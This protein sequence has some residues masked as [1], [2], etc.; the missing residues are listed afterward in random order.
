MTEF[1]LT[2]H[3]A[4]ILAPGAS[5]QLG[6]RVSETTG[7]NSRVLMVC[8]PALVTLGLTGPIVESLKEAGHTVTLFDDLQS[9]PKEASVN[10]ATKLAHENSVDCVVGLGGG[11]A[12]DTS[13]VVAALA[14]TGEGCEPY[15]LAQA[16]LPFR[17]TALITLPTTAGTGSETTGTSIISQPDGVKNWFW[18][19]PLKPDMALMDPELTVGLPAFWTFYTGLDALVHSVESRTNRYRYAQNDAL[20]EEGIVQAARHLVDAVNNPRSIEART[21][22]MLA[23]AY[24]GLAIAN[25]GCAV[26]HNIGHALGSLAGIPH[27]RAVSVALAQTMDWTIDGNREAFDRVGVLLGGKGAGDVEQ[28]LHDVAAKCGEALVLNQD[29]KAKLSEQS[30]ADDMLADANIAMLDATARDASRADVEQLAAR[31]LA[32]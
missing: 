8:D 21:G 32:N 29:E 19:P 11:S 6:D 7:Q 4:M 13:K 14:H 25:T 23:A 31:M 2:K 28:A 30:L 26:A 24:G 17:K 1:S 5:K 3:P 27:G 22:M 10:A 20:A 15:R 12:L 18:G 9:D 16:Q